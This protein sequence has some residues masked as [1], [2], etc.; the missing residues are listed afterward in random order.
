M[1]IL[2]SLLLFLPGALE[3]TLFSITLLVIALYHRRLS[4]RLVARAVFYSTVL[5]WSGIV[6]GQTGSRDVMPLQWLTYFLITLLAYVLLKQKKPLWQRLS[7]PLVA[8]LYALCVWQLTFVRKEARAT[9]AWEIGAKGDP[10]VGHPPEHQVTLRFPSEEYIEIYSDTVA[11]QLRHKGTPTVEVT[12]DLLYHWGKF[13][14]YSLKAVDGKT[15][16]WLGGGGSIG[17]RSFC[18]KYYLGPRGL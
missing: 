6:I 12:L 18:G 10:L 3:L 2:F 17:C 15:A 16:R 4:W 11:T 13:A 14:S 9:A 7:L 5:L 8:A 1:E